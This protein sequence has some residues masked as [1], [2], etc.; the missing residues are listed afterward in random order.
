VLLFYLRLCYGICYNIYNIEFFLPHYLTNVMHKICFTISFIC[1]GIV[2]G[3]E[4]L[5]SAS[6][7]QYIFYSHRTSLYS[8]F[9]RVHAGLLSPYYLIKL[10]LEIPLFFRISLFLSL[11]KFNADFIIFWELCY[12]FLKYT[13]SSSRNAAKLLCF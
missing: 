12:S 2:T 1:Q 7:V 10:W 9:Q 13:S 8:Y 3:R 11:M 4:C 6:A 5:S